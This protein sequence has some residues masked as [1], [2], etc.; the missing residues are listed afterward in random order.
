MTKFWDGQ[1]WLLHCSLILLRAAQLLTDMI[2]DPVVKNRVM[3][4]VMNEPDARGIR[5]P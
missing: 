3:I 1:S 4:D 5:C 2:A